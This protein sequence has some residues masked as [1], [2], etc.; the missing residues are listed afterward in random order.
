MEEQWNSKQKR[1]LPCRSRSL[2]HEFGSGFVA[3]QSRAER[4]IMEP[5]LPPLHYIDLAA[6]FGTRE[7]SGSTP[8][9]K[10]RHGAER[11]YVML[12]ELR[13]TNDRVVNFR[14]TLF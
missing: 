1:N 7:G 6:L 4:R 12:T 11:E 10:T 13:G 2:V 8:G 14:P 5:L 9:A 3:R